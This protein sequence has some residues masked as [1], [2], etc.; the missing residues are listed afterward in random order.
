MTVHGQKGGIIIPLL[1]PRK[2]F[3]SLRAASEAPPEL[4]EPEAELA[5]DS[6]GA[7]ADP[8]ASVADD[9]MVEEAPASAALSSHRP[10]LVESGLNLPPATATN[11]CSNSRKGAAAASLE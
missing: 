5:D 3:I 11:N 6:T 4:S 7:L 8:W 9:G 10:D 2:R 1:G